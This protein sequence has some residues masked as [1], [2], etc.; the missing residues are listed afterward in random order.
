MF[1]S[2]DKK[3]RFVFLERSKSKPN[4]SLILVKITCSFQ[5]WSKGPVDIYGAENSKRTSEKNLVN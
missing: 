2:G 1:E 3:C 5:V 4:A